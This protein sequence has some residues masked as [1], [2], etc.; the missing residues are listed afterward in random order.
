MHHE[1]SISSLLKS[2]LN[3][4]DFCVCINCVQI[5]LMSFSFRRSLTFFWSEIVF[6]VGWRW[7]G[8][9]LSSACWAGPAPTKHGPGLI[10]L[11]YQWARPA[12]HVRGQSRPDGKKWAMRA[13]LIIA[14]SQAWSK[15][16]N[17][18]QTREFRLGE[19]HSKLA[20]PYLCAALFILPYLD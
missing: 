14:N 19:T 16:L 13:D 18:G 1:S 3:D 17:Q 9:G 4:K 15:N 2:T 8:S 20:A 5:I 7:V 10:F 11:K 6:K 12:G